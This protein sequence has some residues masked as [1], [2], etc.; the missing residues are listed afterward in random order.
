[1]TANWEL[2]VFYWQVEI[3]FILQGVSVVAKMKV[4]GRVFLVPSGTCG[5]PI[6]LKI[7]AL[8]QFKLDFF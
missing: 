8:H 6:H 4:D 1:M 5:S 3:V 2:F 7:K